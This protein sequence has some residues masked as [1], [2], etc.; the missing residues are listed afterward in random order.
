MRH[1]TRTLLFAI[2]LATSGLAACGGS[3]DTQ[4]IPAAQ[5]VEPTA[6]PTT[7]E[8]PPSTSADSTDRDPLLFLSGR[9]EV[10]VLDTNSGEKTARAVS[11]MASPDRTAVAQIVGRRVVVLDP[12][13]GDARWDHPV[14]AD[15]RVRVVA[16]GA[17]HIALV[18]GLLATPNLPRAETNLTIVDRDGA[19]ELTLP[20]N[21][22]PEA[23]TL[24]GSDLVA[25][26]Y[27]PAMNP[28]HYEVR[29]VDLATGTIRP[30]PDQ[31]AHFPDNAPRDRM[32]GYARTQVATPDGRSL[33][34]YYSSDV[35]VADDHG[36]MY[37]FVH[38]LDLHH[39]EA[40]CI[41]LMPP[42]G[43]GSQPGAGRVSSPALTLTP[44]GD[45]L[46][47]TD[48]SSGALAAIDTATLEVV[49]ERTLEAAPIEWSPVAT[50]SN[51]VLYLG[52]NREVLRLDATTLTTLDSVA[53]PSA[54][55]G[56]KMDRTSEVLY[57]VTERNI[58][59]L[60]PDGEAIETWALPV[61]GAGAD[62][63]VAVPGRGAYQ[64]AC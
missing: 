52:L 32:Q 10:V 51:E 39:E 50:A 14:P 48:R 47:V 61:A 62:P 41:D 63:A 36:D 28:D 40:Y 53:M 20:G 29:L 27:L 30:V 43:T 17:E 4:P 9:D 35:P 18:D 60:R 26:E 2:S 1:S 44:S 56:I 42:F 64:C 58:Q 8:G 7:N 22:D 59:V 5:A 38:V 21:F 55:T 11:A 15:R 46:L 24:D 45:R 23:F 37:A 19:R 3:A 34:T 49:A 33:Y 16:P 12:G 13:T 6:P 25:V 54:V 31:P 57:A